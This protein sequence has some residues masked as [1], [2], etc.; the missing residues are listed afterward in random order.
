MALGEHFLREIR[1]FVWRRH[2]DFAAVADIH[3]IKRQIHVHK[4]AQG[5]G[6][7]IALAGHDVKLG[8]G[9]IREIEFTAQVLQLIW[10]GRDP[11]LRDPTTLGALA[12]LAAAGRLDRRAAADLADAYVFLR[13]LEHRLQMVADR[14]THRLP[15][16]DAG[17]A[18]I[19]SFMGFAEPREF[20]ARLHGASRPGASATT[21]A[22]SRP[23]PR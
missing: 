1:P 11:A 12:A 8:R 21:R 18:R 23:R 14:Q 13:N 4:G 6:A 17:L 3:S 5:A 7:T 19:A 20:A 9:G 2:L 15:E 22:S 16:D 10:G